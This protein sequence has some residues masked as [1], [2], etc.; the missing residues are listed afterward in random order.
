MGNDRVTARYDP[1]RISPDKM[2][3]AIESAGYKVR[4]R[5]QPGSVETEVREST[6]KTS[7]RREL[8]R[9]LIIA[10]ILTL[11][12]FFAV[13]AHDLFNV[14][15]I[16]SVMLNHWFQL[17]FIT[18]VMFYCGWPIHRTGWLTVSHRTADMNTLIAVGT[19][20]AYVY[21]FIVTV[22]PGI[23]PENLRQVYFESV[24][25]IITLILFGRLIEAIA[26]GGTGEAIRKLIGL[27]A[28]TAR[29]VR[30]GKEQDIPI[31][32]V[33]VG[34]I[35]IVRP[36]EK[37]PVDGEIIEGRS[38][39]DES[40]VTG[41][42]LPATRDK[43]DSVIGATINQTGAFRFRATKVGQDTMLAQIIQLVEQ[44]QGSKAPIQRVADLVA[45]RFVPG[46][47][48]I[49]I[50]T[51]IAWF[52]FGP[53]PAFTFSLVNAVAVLIIACPCAMGLATPLSIM[54]GTG[55][56]AQNGILIRSAEALETAHK[57]QILVLDKTGTI[58]KGKPSLTDVVPVDG[59]SA[60]ELLKLAASAERSSEHPLGQAIIQGARDKGLNLTAPGEFESYTGRG[61]KVAVD[62]RQVL[63]GTRH[64]LEANGIETAALEKEA[65]RLAA[66]GKTS[67]YAAVDGR[68]AGII[69]VADT[70]K[71]ESAAAIAA[72]KRLGID[73]VMITGDNRHTAA[74]IARQVGIERVLAEVLPRD[75]ALEIKRLQAENK[76]VGMVGDGINDAPAL[77][78]ADI[79]IAIGTGTDIAIESSDITL[80]SGELKGVVTAI[81]LS[82]AAMR[83]IRQNLTWAFIYNVI[84]IPIAAGALYPAF[85]ILLSP[86]IGAAAMAFSSLS[87]VTNANRLRTYKA[88][89]LAAPE[90]VKIEPKVEICEPQEAGT[91]ATVKDLVCGMEIDP[92]T[93][94]AKLDY[95]GKPYYFCALSCRDKFKA[96]PEKF[97]K[98]G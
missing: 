3:K 47:I 58:T 80:I 26:K 62:G 51:F 20:A 12:V 61:I 45:S 14:T 31:E 53:A 27:Q 24:G 37:V 32:Q 87:V 38:T 97:I 78:Q 5:S 36:G 40:M 59:I 85:G 29:V 94:A 28:R 72:L 21:S 43:G 48:F 44:A 19:T 65:E 81:T 55:K 54:V 39:L 1:S 86:M 52:N 89:P 67:I 82:R 74:A 25:V 15:W 70:V 56:A 13:M 73:V 91:M 35:I 41:E 64:L 98:K 63:V 79:G 18:P 92:K 84:G 88:P 16:P 71:E 22:A 83:N 60:D 57:L 33:Q 77:A 4:R 46:V 11:P 76:L 49:A 96:D 7:E 34:D 50:I 8:S 10:A 2:Q 42:S 30:E 90:P 75:K 66:E 95:K 68:P 23:L 93:A 6:A 69:A 9:R 17:G